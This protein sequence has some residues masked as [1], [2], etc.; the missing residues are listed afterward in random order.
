MRIEFEGRC[1]CK[2]PIAVIFYSEKARRFTLTRWDVPP[3]VLL[4]D[5][6]DADDGGHEVPR[7]A[8]RDPVV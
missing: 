4:R 3:C 7:P 8:P 2:I 5:D 1:P 6:V